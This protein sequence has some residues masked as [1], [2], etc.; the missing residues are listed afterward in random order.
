MCPHGQ[1]ELAHMQNPSQ[2]ISQ[3]NVN[4]RNR[5][6]NSVT[7]STDGYI[8]SAN[9]K[10]PRSSRIA[11]RVHVE[12]SHTPANPKSFSSGLTVPTCNACVESNSGDCKVDV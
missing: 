2:A 8:I 11:H 5:K 9:A 10:L 1:P 4:K 6:I 12:A 3:A 7:L